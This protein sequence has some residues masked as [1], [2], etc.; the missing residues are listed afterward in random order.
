[1]WQKGNDMLRIVLLLQG[2]E[3]TCKFARAIESVNKTYK[4]RFHIRTYETP[5]LDYDEAQFEDCLFQVENADFVFINTHGG[6]SYFKGFLKIRERIKNKKFYVLSGMDSENSELM[7]E[8]RLLPEEYT[9]ITQ[10][11]EAGGWGNY[12]QML[13]YIAS[14]VCGQDVTYKKVALPVWQGIYGLPE[15]VNEHEFIRSVDNYT[16]PVIGLIVH[17]SNMANENTRHIDALIEAVEAAGAKAYPIFSSMAPD[18][19]TKALGLSQTIEKYFMDGERSRIDALIVTCG[20]SLTILSNPGDGSGRVKTSVFERLNV[21][22][23]Q[24]M[25]TYFNLEQWKDSPMGMDSMLLSSNVYQTEFDGQVL[26]VPIA[27]T[28]MITTPYGMKTAAFPIPDRVQKVAGLA[29]KWARLRYIPYEK[30]RIAII[31]HNMPPRNDMIGCA[32][33]LDTPR[34]VYNL[35]QALQKN[36]LYT[37]YDF[38]DGQEIIDKIIDGLTNDGRFL[39]PEDMLKRSVDTVSERVY[40]SWY[41]QFDDKVQSELFRDW[42]KAPGEFMAVNGEILIPGILNGHLFIGLQP[43]RALEEKAE[44][45]YHST[46]MVCPHQ[47]LGFY[48]WVERVF[49]ADVIVHVGTHGT[50]EWLPGKEVG[51]SSSCYPD[52]AI[53]EI[54]HLYPY[55]IDVPGEGVQAKRRSCACLLDHLIP[56]MKESGL[57]G[58][59]Q[60]LDDRIEQYYHA[61][62]GDLAKLPVIADQIWEFACKQNLDCDLNMEKRDFEDDV[63]GCIER[64]HVWVSEIKNSEIKDGLHIFG[65]APE[66]ERLSNMLRLLVR[67]RNGNIP[68]LREG[69]CA[70]YGLD[71]QELIKCPESIRED[72]RTNAMVL[73]EM[74]EKGRLIFDSLEKY[75]YDTDCIEECIRTVLGQGN[76]KT[77]YKCLEYVCQTL[78]PKLNQT[79]DEI[80]YFLKGI[81]GEFVPPGPSGCPSRGNPDILPTGR[82]FYTIDPSCVPSRASWKIG[83]TLG[84]QMIERYVRDEG[85]AP[86]NVAIVVYSGETMKTYGD[87]IAE[88]MYLYGI[89][90]V[91]LGD[92]DRVVGLEVIPLSELGRPRIDV[93]LRI[94]GLFRDTFPNLIERIEDAVNLVSSLDEPLEQNYIKKH[95]SEDIIQWKKEGLD[96]EQAFEKASIRVFGCPPGTYGAGVDIL[97]NS[98]KWETTEDLGEAYTNWGAHAYGKRLH[99]EK[100]PK[101]FAKRLSDCDVTIKNVSSVEADMLDSDD[102]YNYHGGLISAVKKHSGKMPKSYSTNGADPQNIVTRDIHEETSRIMRARINNPEWIAGLKEHGFRGAQEISAMMDIVFGWDATSEVVDDWMYESITQ[103]YLMDRE[104]RDWIN[105]VNPWALHAISERL[106][107]ASQRGMWNAKEESLSAVRE[108]YLEM[109]GSIE[110]IQ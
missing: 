92:S 3:Y 100:C 23:L 27:Y 5:M 6:L 93:V 42:G 109:E 4:D 39:L 53:G 63:D 58:E 81:Q 71:D 101:V 66:N 80:R 44:E 13:R 86:E 62:Q 65:Q 78:V 56:S 76:E 84:D 29:I 60:E 17:Y 98:K 36:G 31:L 64:M 16:G 110:E 43:P 8:M 79:T 72:G 25:T 15:N 38:T 11:F 89:R 70:F 50:L 106:L 95:I 37:E 40:R 41:G 20:F 34:S 26:S 67:I 82:N 57:Y 77:L 61:R 18:R 45:A 87:D 33:G 22:V 73:G 2:S 48:K 75:G 54:P 88:I 102:F 97:V 96:H 47:Y 21:P 52:V 99:G 28:D 94:S 35:V 30:K 108:I 19:R 107:E 12:E 9:K 74:D 24:A 85:K 32:Y 49:Q 10:Y 46:D 103:T 7:G 69:L 83:K 59:L 91:W 14:Q 105:D 1:M 51:L 68:S 90:P 55:I 104:V